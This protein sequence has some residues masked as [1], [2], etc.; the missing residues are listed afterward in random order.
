[1]AIG[2]GA[3][4]AA[5]T[6]MPLG[7]ENPEYFKVDANCRISAILASGTGSLYISKMG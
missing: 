1:V 5:A 4:A 3:I 2:E 6:D 7:G